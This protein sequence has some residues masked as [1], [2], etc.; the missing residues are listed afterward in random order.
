MPFFR[1]TKNLFITFSLLALFVREQQNH[2][3]INTTEGQSVLLK[4]RFNTSQ[5]KSLGFT[6]VTPLWRKKDRSKIDI[7]TFNDE[8]FDQSYNLTYDVINGVYDL[9]IESA[10]Y[11]RDNY[12][13]ECA[14]KQKGS[15]R[16]YI[17]VSYDITAKV[18]QDDIPMAYEGYY[19]AN[20]NLLAFRV[21]QSTYRMPLIARI[22]HL[23][24]NSSWKL[25]T[26][27]P[28][29]SELETVRLDPPADNVGYGDIRVTLC[30]A[31]RDSW[32]GYPSFSWGSQNGDAIN[33]CDPNSCENG[34]TC[35]SAH[36]NYTCECPKGYEGKITCCCLI[37]S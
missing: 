30:L 25:I 16:E 12:N 21:N 27:T 17:V 29:R 19:D 35:H 23:V 11:D 1:L 24:A 14:L 32:C 2:V 10:T 37:S 13:F 26:K 3:S 20:D 4:C 33:F 36:M 5:L 6:K 8:Y 34:A 31:S 28:V 9:I 22:E 7:V 15:S 18:N